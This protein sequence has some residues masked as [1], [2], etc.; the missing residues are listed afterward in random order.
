MNEKRLDLNLLAVFDAVAASGSVTGAAE[1]LSLSQPAVSHALNRLRAL[2]GDPLFVR[3]RRG[4][5]PTPR[6]EAM[7]APVR[8]ILS[9]SAAVLSN[10]AFVPADSERRFRVGASDYASLT[11]IPALARTCRSSALRIRLEMRPVERTTLAELESGELDCAFWGADP[12]GPPWRMSRLFVERLIGM[13]AEDHPLAGRLKAGNR[14]TLDDYLAYPHVSVSMRAP[15][16]S[17]VDSALAALGRS[18]MVGV[19]TQSFAANMESLRRTDLIA[20]IPSRLA[21][22]APGGLL[23]FQLPLALADYDYTLVWHLRT[24]A[25]PANEWLRREIHRI[26]SGL[27]QA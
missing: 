21:L 12:P 11:V 1:R 2:T 5:A 7:R 19:V 18:R 26:S 16:G 3:S 6:A 27:A 22:D 15:G 23:T 17:P 13:I 14:M 20:S 24:D 8:D 4:L 25:D 10:A 9:A